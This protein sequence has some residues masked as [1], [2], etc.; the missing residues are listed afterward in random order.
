MYY[1]FFQK[2]RITLTK[3][4]IIT[5]TMIKIIKAEIEHCELIAKI[6]KQSFIESHGESASKSD[7]DVFIS[8]TFT[9]EILLTQLSNPNIRY[10]LIYYNNNVAGYSKI[11]LDSPNSNIQNKNVTKLERFYLLKEFYGQKLGLKLFEF[12]VELSKKNQ[13]KGIWLAVWVE[14][15]RAIKFYTKIGFKIVGKYD[16]KIS[17]THSNPN[18]IMYLSF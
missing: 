6:G 12:N 16:F 3:M 15:L 1:A 17:N 4:S 13:Q 11:E 10:H 9:K 14:N 18:H 2:F 5:Y 8:K 7:I